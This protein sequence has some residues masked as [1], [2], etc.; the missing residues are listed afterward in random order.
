MKVKVLKEF[1]AVPPGAIGEVVKGIRNDGSIEG[2]IYIKFECK[3]DTVLIG[4]PL[5]EYY[6]V[7]V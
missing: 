6:R 4:Y 7:V 1:L 2:G 3:C 5:D